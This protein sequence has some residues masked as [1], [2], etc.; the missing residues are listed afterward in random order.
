MQ[1][2]YSRL[3]EKNFQLFF[4]EDDLAKNFRYTNSLPNKMVECHLKLKDDLIV[5]GL[6]FFF[7]T[8]NYLLREKLDYVPWLELEG[9]TVA[10]SAAKEIVFELPFNIAL[11]GERI[12]LNLLQRA[13]SIASYTQKYV[14]AA[15]K[16]K[17]LDT[18]KTTPGLRFLEKYAVNKGGGYNHRFSQLDTWMIKDNHKT[19][20]G[21]LGPAVDFFV[22]QKAN[23]QSLVVEIHDLA[24]LKQAA[25]LN[26]QN[27]MLDNFTREELHSAI[28]FKQPNWHYEVSG[29]IT[30][31]NLKEYALEGVDAISCG[32]I[33]YNAPQ[34]DI[35]LKYF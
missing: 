28:E 30:L 31:T 32:S 22:S 26:L 10:K 19:F 34:V 25:H 1:M 15:G 7:E 3:F 8:F 12:A 24:E 13:S 23:Y 21:G 18:R 16:V 17:I 6:P 29:G 27:F 5:A 35:S 9:K 33:T 11:C 14:E 2:D 20:F 4:E